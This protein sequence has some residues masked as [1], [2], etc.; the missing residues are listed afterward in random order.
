MD[1]LNTEI[2]SSA[3]PNIITKNETLKELKEKQHKESNI[4]GFELVPLTSETLC[5]SGDTTILQ[6]TTNKFS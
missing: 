3:S 2:T 4:I 5:L 6:G 1:N